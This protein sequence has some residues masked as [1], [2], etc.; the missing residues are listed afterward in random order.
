MVFSTGQ[1]SP[2]RLHLQSNTGDG[3][4]GD[5]LSIHQP[6]MTQPHHGHWLRRHDWDGCKSFDKPRK[7]ESAGSEV[8][9]AEFHWVGT[10]H[11]RYRTHSSSSLH[12]LSSKGNGLFEEAATLRHF[13]FSELSSSPSRAQDHMQQHQDSERISPHG[14]GEI[15]SHHKPQAVY[16]QDRRKNPNFNCLKTHMTM[17]LSFRNH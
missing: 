15:C 13:P 1:P 11:H 2:R 6:G 5:L 16:S 12:L 9:K 3:E 8:C 10:Y 17:Q 4:A 14:G 7:N